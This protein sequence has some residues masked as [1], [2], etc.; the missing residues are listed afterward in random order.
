MNTLRKSLGA[1]CAL[2]LGATLQAAIQPTGT[3]YNV[4]GGQ[5]RGKIQ[6]RN[7]AKEYVVTTDRG[8]FTFPADQVERVEVNPPAELAA[9]VKR[10][11]AG[12][13]AA[14]IPTLQEI[15]KEYRNLTYDVEATR[16]LIAAYLAQGKAGDAVRAAETVI[17]DK[18]EA[19]YMGEMAVQYW[20]ALIKDN[21]ASSLNRLLEKAIAS[22]DKTAAAEALV[23]RGDSIMARGASRANA[24]EALRDG[25]L[26]VILLYA[27]PAL[28]AYPAALYKGA[29]AFDG[30][31]QGSRANTLR[32]KLKAECPTSEW[33]RK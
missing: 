17:R 32:E 24:E 25:Y 3:V 26:R 5:S 14:A 28:P 22:G 11:Q 19:A 15:A 31:G 18:P 21:K 29:Q 20:Q 9:A 6:W 33:A 7:A 13:A 27:D 12:S 30:M 23:A 2:V 16:W 1:L 10:V 8:Q 4:N